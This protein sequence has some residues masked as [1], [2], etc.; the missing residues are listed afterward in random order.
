MERASSRSTS[1][2]SSIRRQ[3]A[4]RLDT[5]VLFYLNKKAKNQGKTL[6]AFVSE[7]LTKAVQDDLDGWPHID[8]PIEISDTVKRM[9]IG[10]KFTPEELAADE[11]LAYILSK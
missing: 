6:N 7:V 3:T 4:F 5:E 9:C 10:I 1:R 11:R 2:N 8:G